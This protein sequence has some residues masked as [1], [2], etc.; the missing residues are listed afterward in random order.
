VKLTIGNA[1]FGSNSETRGRLYD[2]L[3]NN[4]VQFPVGPIVTLHGQI[5][6][7]EKVDRLD[8]QVHPMI[9]TLFPNSDAAFQG[10]NAPI[11]TAGTVQS[12]FEKHEGELQ[13]FPW[14]AKSSHL[15][16]TEPRGSGL[17]TRVRNIFPS[18]ASLKQLEDIL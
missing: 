17:E 15:N 4:V 1:C 16:I 6:A 5:T 18:L 12:W 14:P 7:R 10:D 3:G 8:N 2:G 13:H 11:H 9:R